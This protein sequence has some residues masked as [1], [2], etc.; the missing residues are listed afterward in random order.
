MRVFPIKKLGFIWICERIKG[1]RE[2][3]EKGYELLEKRMRN[4]RGFKDRS[5]GK[6]LH[7]VFENKQDQLPKR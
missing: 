2:L 4:Y 6:K 7:F 5:H 1:F 3:D